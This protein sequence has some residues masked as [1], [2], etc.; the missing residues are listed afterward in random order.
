MVHILDI[1]SNLLIVNIGTIEP[2]IET[3]TGDITSY[4]IIPAD[5]EPH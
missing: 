2:T 5:S 4:T 3:L 1:V